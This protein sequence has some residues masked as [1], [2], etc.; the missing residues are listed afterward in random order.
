[1]RKHVLW[2]VAAIIINCYNDEEL[3]NGQTAPR[4]YEK[5]HRE[6]INKFIIKCSLLTDKQPK[7]VRDL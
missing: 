7:P 1:M 5:N 2:K 6:L 3:A 4:C